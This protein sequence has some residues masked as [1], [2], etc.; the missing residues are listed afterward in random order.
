MVHDDGAFY[1]AAGFFEEVEGGFAGE[2]G[3]RLGDDADGAV[4]EFGV[5]HG[6]D[7]DHEVAVGFSDLDHG[8]GGDGV[9]DEFGGGAGFEAGGAGEN[10]GAGGESDEDVGDA[11][12]ELDVGGIGADEEDGGG[13]AGVGFD[14]GAV[15]VGGGAARGDAEEDVFFGDG[16]VW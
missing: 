9:E 7:V 11:S 5:F 8:Q 12:G 3:V 16:F 13:V 10:F 2:A 15:D 4:A 1:F 14:E 6:V